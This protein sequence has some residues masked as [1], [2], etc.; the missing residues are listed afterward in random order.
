M[1]MYLSLNARLKHSNLFTVIDAP[2][3]AART[4]IKARNTTRR[5][6]DAG[7]TARAQSNAR[8]QSTSTRRKSGGPAPTPEIQLRAF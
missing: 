5:K 4:P 6:H 3:N 2:L 7:V 1:L 8:P